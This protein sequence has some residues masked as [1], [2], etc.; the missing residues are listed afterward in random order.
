[1]RYLVIAAVL[2]CASVQAKPKPNPK[3]YIV[4][5][6]EIFCFKQELIIKQLQDNYGE[7]PIFMGKSSIEKGGSVVVTVNQST[8]S[9]TVLEVGDGIGCV[10]DSGKNMRYRMPKTLENSLM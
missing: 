5:P 7:E 10:L 8:G 6:T 1:M 9:Y 3:D 2:L 4:V